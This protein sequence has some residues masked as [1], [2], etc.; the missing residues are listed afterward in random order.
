MA[1]VAAP[2]A[3]AAAPVAAPAT[4]TA[5]AQTAQRGPDGKFAPTAPATEA[6]KPT[7]PTPRPAPK[8]DMK[9]ILDEL[10]PRQAAERAAKEA[11]AK[12]TP[13]EVPPTP[14]AE[15]APEPGKPEKVESAPA[16]PEAPEKPEA[17][18]DMTD[19]PPKLAEHIKTI[20]DPKARKEIKGKV[21]LA[22]DYA[23]LMPIAEV[24][25]RKLMAPTIEVERE[26]H[27]AAQRAFQLRDAFVS[28][29]PEGL[30]HFAESLRQEAPQ[31]YDALIS[32]ELGSLEQ[33]NPAAFVSVAERGVKNLASILRSQAQRG[34]PVK[35]ISAE[36][37]GT[38]ADLIEAYMGFGDRQ[39]GGQQAST[40]APEIQAELTKL[41]QEKA[42]VQQNQTR[43]FIGSVGT[44][45]DKALDTEVGNVI[46]AADPDGLWG[47]PTRKRLSN[48]IKKSIAESVRGN[49]ALRTATSNI[50]RSGDENALYN[51]L[52]N[53]ARGLLGPI[54]RDHIA[55]VRAEFSQA[56]TQREAK[57]TAQMSRRDLGSGGLASGAAAQPPIP[58]NGSDPKGFLSQWFDRKNA[59]R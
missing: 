31:A 51:H 47:E 37:L 12:K 34:Q 16:K 2:A 33:S 6:A 3:P 4:T 46:S 17:A 43:Q 49:Q 5:P 13:P 28:G 52:I 42:Q 8:G 44:A 19:V 32:R 59:A 56:Q 1:E 27:H 21:I 11:E 7:T 57:Q 10:I 54:S 18:D 38:M 40:V 30:T 53:N 36:D 45:Y 26:T 9:E 14:K 15:A 29:S 50:L 58:F 55:G 35:G 41:R 20:A 24:K 23:E 22:D 48:D 39:Q 25:E